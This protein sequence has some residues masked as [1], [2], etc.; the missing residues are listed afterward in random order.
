MSHR[1]R[2]STL[3]FLCHS[4]SHSRGHLS[5]RHARCTV[6]MTRSPLVLRHR[7]V[8]MTS[9]CRAFPLVFTLHGRICHRFCSGSRFLSRVSLH[10]TRMSSRHLSFHRSTVT[11]CSRHATRMSSRHLALHC[12][13][14]TLL[15]AFSHHR[16][17]H[18][19]MRLGEGCINFAGFLQLLW[20]DT[21][22][23][24]DGLVRHHAF[25]VEQ[26]SHQLASRYEI[27]LSKQ[28]CSALEI[29]RHT[30]LQFV[31]SQLTIGDGVGRHGINTTLDV[32]GCVDFSQDVGTTIDFL[33]GKFLGKV[34]N[35]LDVCLGVGTCAHA[36]ET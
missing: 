5:V 19:T 15:S 24:A 4:C 6:G 9:T 22:H 25:L 13:H 1:S 27:F 34:L 31:D 10:S 21:R 18:P 11:F 2:L 23:L 32:S 30:M 17:H 16:C 33:I 28:G 26:T 8:G 29:G 35:A 36:V 14:T 20:G 7:S 12:R 3:G